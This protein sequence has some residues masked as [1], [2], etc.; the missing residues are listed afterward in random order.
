M[1]TSLTDQTYAIPSISTLL[2]KTGQFSNSSTAYKRYSDTS[3]L[4]GEFTASRPSSDRARTAI[5]RTN[6]L[7][8][9]YRASGKIR[10]DDMLYTLSLFAGEPIRFINRYEW[11]V[12]SVLEKCAVGTFWKSLGDALEVSYE[13]LPSSKDG[14]RDG[15]HWLEEVMAWSRAY[16]E[17][18]MVPHA[19]NKEVADKTVDIL[20]FGVPEFLKPLGC[21]LVSYLMEDRLREAML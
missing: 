10:D 17:E 12:L 4:I 18:H 13:C 11:R 19:K 1:T 20:L 8:S 14:F 15:I 7:H 3:V 21:Y 9:A 16:E 5:A 6:L 2:A